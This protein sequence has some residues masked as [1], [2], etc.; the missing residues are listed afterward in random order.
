M[1]VSHKHKFIFLKTSKT[2]STSVEIALSKFCGEQD[3]ITPLHTEDEKIRQSLGYRGAQNWRLSPESYGINDTPNQLAFSAHTNAKKLRAALPKTIWDHYFKFCVV[4]NPWDRAISMHY[5]RNRE[6]SLSLNQFLSAGPP[7]TLRQFG[8]G[9]YTINNK[10][11]VDALCRYEHLAT[12]LE[13]SRRTIGLPEPLELPQ[14]KTDLRPN[15]ARADD[16]LTPEQFESIR[17]FCQDEL[18]LINKL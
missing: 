8:V 12:D 6:N 18:M 1:I 3:I 15:S 14:A 7:N 10:V 17:D 2:A 4:R 9:I 11:A 13:T 16:L 5:W